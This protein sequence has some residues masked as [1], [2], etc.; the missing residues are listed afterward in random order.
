MHGIAPT[1]TEDAW[2]R[3]YKRRR[4]VASPVKAQEMRGIVLGYNARGSLLG[5]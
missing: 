1:G 2:R 3:P 5:A 4:C